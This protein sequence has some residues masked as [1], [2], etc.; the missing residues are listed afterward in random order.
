MN[1]GDCKGNKVV[2]EKVSL[3][4]CAILLLVISVT[5]F[6]AVTPAATSGSVPGFGSMD[7]RHLPDTGLTKCYDDT[8]NNEIPLDTCPS[9]GEPFYGQDANYVRYRLSYTIIEGVNGEQAVLDNNTGL[10]WRPRPFDYNSDGILDYRDRYSLDVAKELCSNSTWAGY[11]DWRLPEF[12]ELLT[13]MD[14][15][16]SDPMIDTD[17]FH[18]GP[19]RYF[20]TNTWIDPFG[21]GTA[22]LYGALIFSSGYNTWFDKSADYSA[23][24]VRGGARN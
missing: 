18:L 3:R 16:R 22:I 21:D 20:W 10:M 2:P 5:T 19:M 24:C 13:I 11:D 17:Y 15:S 12:Y 14:Y 23:L 6:A 8:P 7:F 4:I 1:T 9:E